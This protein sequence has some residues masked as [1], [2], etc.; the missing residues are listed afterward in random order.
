MIGWAAVAALPSAVRIRRSGIVPV[1]PHRV[2][3]SGPPG[4]LRW[5]PICAAC[6]SDASA[7]LPVTRVD[8]RDWRY[9][10]A[11]RSAD[12]FAIVAVCTID[13]PF[14]AACVA[15]HR[16]ETRGNAAVRAVVSVF[17]T[18]YV[19]PLIVVVTGL[20]AGL[21]PEGFGLA[22][23]P[24]S[25]PTTATQRAAFALVAAG[26][27]AAVCYQTRWRRV[28]PPTSVTEAFDFSDN[29]AGWFEPERRV[30]GMT[31][32]RFAQAVIDANRSRVQP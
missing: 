7:T 16:G 2:A 15:R 23:V 4:T 10:T 3:L 27:A 18:V 11:T 30:Y 28:P 21:D 26:F 24:I 31:P 5:P 32:A 29:L 12:H 14:C 1:R 19:I 17:S 22:G 13:V 20:V 9:T 8:L 6:G 25:L